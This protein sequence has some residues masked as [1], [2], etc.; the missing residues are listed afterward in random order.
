[1]NNLKKDAEDIAVSLI[2]T[3]RRI[4]TPIFEKY[5]SVYKYINMFFYI[6][7]A[8]ILFG[9]YNMTPEYIP[10]LRNWILYIAVF[11]LILRFNPL[12]WYNPKFAIIGGNKFS[13]MDRK[14]IISTCVF[15]LIT[16]IV[17]NVVADYTNQKIK[18]N[19]TQPLSRTVIQPIYQYIDTSGAV[20]KFPV[21]K[22]FFQD[23]ASG[24][25]G[26]GGDP[27]RHQEQPSPQ[28]LEVSSLTKN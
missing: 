24:G 7:Y 11:I 20:D 14:L 13:E 22:K 10:T 2:A 4:I 12:S 1:M 15:I 17:S 9:F 25:G 16:H 27:S 6:T 26:G 5:S 19:I 21:M 18:Q 23:G 8:I 3:F 28:P